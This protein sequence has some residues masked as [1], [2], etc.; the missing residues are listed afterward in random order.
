MIFDIDGTLVDSV[1]T[2]RVLAERVAGPLGYNITHEVICNALNTQQLFW[3]TLIPPDEPRRDEVI[4]SLRTQALRLWP[5]VLREHGKVIPGTGGTLELLKERGAQLGIV[6]ASRQPSFL[7]LEENGLLEGFSA[8]VTGMDVERRKPDPEGLLKC[9][10][11]LKVDACDA[12]YVGDT[13]LDI[14]A[15][16]AAGM[17]AVGVLTGAGDSDLLSAEGADRIIA[18]IEQLAGIVEIR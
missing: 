14:R 6:T 4:S 1:H 7:P 5:Q 18:S 13:A 12:V 9:A 17:A 2:Y 16:K 3:H 8:V 15:G 10:E 11:M